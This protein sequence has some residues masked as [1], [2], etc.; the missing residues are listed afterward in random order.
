[1]AESR[2]GIII[3]TDPD[4]VA[5]LLSMGIGKKKEDG[6]HLHWLEAALLSE[7][8]LLKI[9]Q[10]GKELSRDALIAEPQEEKKG[11][12]EAKKE[13]GK[14][15][16]KPKIA[17]NK[18]ADSSGASLLIPSRADQYLI[19]RALRLGGRVVRF[20][21]G[22]PLHWRVYERGVGREHERP[23]MLLYLVTPE[24]SVSLSSLEQQMQLARMLRQDL[25]LAFVRD[26]RPHMMRMSR[27]PVE[28]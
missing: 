24:W 4:M 11:A 18:S 9:E 8:N 27:P 28:G 1:M 12:K 22:S 6:L 3:E 23:Q 21:E 10:E 20:S 15:S 14:K 5:K 26:G 16:A 17:K 13:K 2:A 7:R 19:Y 25:T